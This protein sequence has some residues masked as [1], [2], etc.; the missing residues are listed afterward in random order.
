VPGAVGSPLT[1]AMSAPG[2]SK[3][4]ANHL[5]AAGSAD[6]CAAAAA[7]DTSDSVAATRTAV[8][9][10]VAAPMRNPDAPFIVASRERP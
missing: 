1:T 3:G 6:A 5:S 7:A 8:L 9:V 4:G 10:L 2:G